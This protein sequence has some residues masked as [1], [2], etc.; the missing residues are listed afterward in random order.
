[1]DINE[2]LVEKLKLKLKLKKDYELASFFNVTPFIFSTWKKSRYKLLYETVKYG[3]ENNL[4]FNSI[5]FDFEERIDR[6]QNSI[7]LLTAEDLFS[8]YLNPED[9]SENR[10][11]HVIT[12]LKEST[13]GFQMI[14]QN[15]EPS[16]SVSSYVFGVPIAIDALET[17]AIYVVNVKEKGIY[18]SRFTNRLNGHFNF[19]NDNSKF[20]SYSFKEESIIEVFSVEAN[21]KNFA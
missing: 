19:D 9:E 18:I 21:F 8:Y 16:I 14:S 2:L 20:D 6:K 12:L 13:I 5:F 1:M 17:N 10:K 11:E 4:D 15:M 3:L 7:R